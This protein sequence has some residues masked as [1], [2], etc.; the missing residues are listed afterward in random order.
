MKRLAVIGALSKV[1][2]DIYW[3]TLGAEAGKE[4]GP[5]ILPP[6]LVQGFYA[7]DC[8]SKLRAG[9]WS[10]LVD[11]L[12]EEALGA[13]AFGAEGVIIADSALNPAGPTIRRK[14]KLPVIDLGHAVRK[15]LQSLGF[16]RIGLMGCHSPREER[17]WREGLSGIEV[18]V[19]SSA[20]QAWLCRYL[21]ATLRGEPMPPTWA[22]RSYY[23]LS[24]F[25]KR[26]A[27]VVV[28][29]SPSLTVLLNSGEPMIPPMLDATT[30]HA[31]A[32]ALWAL[33]PDSVPPTP[34]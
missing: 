31:W 20:D 12:L 24:D 16:G 11:T 2:A 28:I 15:K 29:T 34:Q 13:Q 17:M 30:I 5:E 22:V 33:S 6:V 7:H 19:P 9:D 27:Q 23:I 3:H 10:G 14:L 26:R 21:A 32:A 8:A 4:L 25:R 1:S 18:L